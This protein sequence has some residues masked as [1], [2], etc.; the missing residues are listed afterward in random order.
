MSQ[1]NG[2]FWDLTPEE[3]GAAYDK[4]EQETGQN[5]HDLSAEERGRYY[6]WGV[7]NSRS[8]DWQG[9]EE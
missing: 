8:F 6:D 1:V 9:W 7:D 3:R 2:G 4:A 5:F